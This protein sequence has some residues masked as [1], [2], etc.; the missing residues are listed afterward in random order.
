MQFL[1][2]QQAGSGSTVPNHLKFHTDLIN[3]AIGFLTV[4]EGGNNSLRLEL[5]EY[6]EG[7]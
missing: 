2:L 5:G 3:T 6:D 1:Q 7:V 4:D